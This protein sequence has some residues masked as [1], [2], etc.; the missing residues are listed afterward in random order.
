VEARP[1]LKDAASVHPDLAEISTSVVDHEGRPAV[2]FGTGHPYALGF[3]VIDDAGDS[4]SIAL[5]EPVPLDGDPGEHT[6]RVATRTRYGTLRPSQL[7][8]TSRRR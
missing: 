7:A 5:D 1:L 2:L 3:L 8:Y 6:W 4:R